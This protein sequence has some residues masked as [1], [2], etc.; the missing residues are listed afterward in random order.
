MAR[1]IKSTP[2]FVAQSLAAGSA[3]TATA[4]DISASDALALYLTSITGTTP[5][6]TFTYSLC[7]TT[8]PTSTFIVPQSPVTIGATKSAVDVMDFAPEA[9][10]Y[11]KI[12]ATNAGTGTI[13]FTS[14]LVAQEA[15]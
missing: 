3:V 1:R 13:V 8:D 15:E 9:S 6:V 5:S 12:I 11:I 4:C 7:P 2:V 10:N 14:Y